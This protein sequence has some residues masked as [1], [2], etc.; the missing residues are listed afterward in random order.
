MFLPGSTTHGLAHALLSHDFQLS[1][2]STFCIPFLYRDWRV[3]GQV[4]PLKAL[5]EEAGGGSNK[6]TT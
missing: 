5:E 6:V 4:P 1:T 3:N 2:L